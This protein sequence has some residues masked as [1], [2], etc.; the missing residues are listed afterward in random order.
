MPAVDHLTAA[1]LHERRMSVQLQL[2]GTQKTERAEREQLRSE[3]A[4]LEEQARSLKEREAIEKKRATFAGIGSP[5]H[6]AVRD[7]VGAGAPEVVARIEARAIEILAD[8]ERHNAERR[9]A[10]Q[11]TKAVATAPDPSRSETS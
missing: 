8:R 7:I 11:V 4:L 5:L 2:A 1:Q 6:Q 10:K 9:A 3:L